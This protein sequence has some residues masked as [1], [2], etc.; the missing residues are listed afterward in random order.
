MSGTAPTSYDEVPY[1]S[2]PYPQTH[3]DRLATI[4]ALFAVQAAPVERCRLL[5]IG[6]A[7]GGNL[8]PLAE[9]LPEA[10]F[11]GIDLSE[12]QIGEGREALAALGLR[13]VEL[14]P[15]SVLDVGPDFG[16][17][18]YVLCHG[19]YSWVPPQARDKILDVCKNNL[20]PNGVAYV[21]YNT[22]PGWH[23]RGMIRDMM[24]IHAAQFPSPQQRVEQGRA[25]L[26]FLA[27]SAAEEGGP[28]STFLRSELDLLARKAD[29]YVLHEHLEEHNQPVYFHQFIRAAAERGLCYLGEAGLPAMVPANFPPAVQAT[30]DKLAADQVHLEQYM[31]F[32]RNRMFRQTLLCH[33]EQ[34]PVYR[35]S[36][37]RL[38]PHW[39]AS[40]AGHSR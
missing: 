2:Y 34:R 17:F 10:T 32:L 20:A 33:A 31:D 28:Y 11:V 23:M 6:C 26:D 7:S 9:S 4:A 24:L 22:L 8:L 18:D 12:R 21:S 40:P 16:T 1:A 5:E 19:V 39:V 36:A 3:P 15:L 25:L 37:E 29:S 14:R 38:L 27:Q 35:V 13:N 30:L